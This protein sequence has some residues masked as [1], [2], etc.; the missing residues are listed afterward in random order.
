[1]IEAV[2]IALIFAKIKGYNLKPFFKSWTIYPILIFELMYIFFQ[3]NIFMGNYE[4]INCAI[5]FKEIYMYLFLIPIFRYREYISALIGS[6]FIFAGTFLNHLVIAANGGQMPVFPSLSYLTGY[7]KP[8]TFSKIQD[9]H[10][11]GDGSVKLKFLSDIIDVGYSVLSI[12]DI[13]IRVFVV[14]IIYVTV[15]RVNEE[16]EKKTRIFS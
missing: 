3:I 5:W 15:K 13:L 4:Y 16:S 14:I 10:M 11:V 9:I 12:G 8:D 2:V 6:V 7:V 1:M